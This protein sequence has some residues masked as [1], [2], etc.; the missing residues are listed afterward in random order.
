MIRLLALLARTGRLGDGL[1]QQLIKI[2]FARIARHRPDRRRDHQRAEIR[3]V[4]GFV[5]SNKK[6]PVSLRLV[7]LSQET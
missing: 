6:S 7:W 4:A 2:G 1:A 3:S 5:R